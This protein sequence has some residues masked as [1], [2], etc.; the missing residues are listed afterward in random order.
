MPLEELWELFP[1]VLVPHDDAW[2][3][4]YKEAES[5]LRSLLSAFPVL[6][7]S[8]IGSTAIDGIQ[9]KPIVDVLVEFEKA[10][11]LA[12]RRIRYTMGDSLLCPSRKIAFP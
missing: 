3:D 8:H 12:R 10:P 11:T 4:Y 2:L 1:I 7:I 5:R 6:R 9:A